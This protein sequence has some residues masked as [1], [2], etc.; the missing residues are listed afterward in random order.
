[1]R[2]DAEERYVSYAFIRQS[3]NQ[4]SNLKADLQNDFTTGDNC[5]PKNLQK[6]LNLLEK[7]N[8]TDVSKVTQS[9]G[10]SFSQRSGRGG[11]RGGRSGNGKKHDTFYKEYW[12][13]KTCYKFEK[14]GRPANK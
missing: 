8:K 6:T 3:G 7:Y 10:T 14:K 2:D 9:E 1:V 12:K 4:H 11:G 5:Y 13:D